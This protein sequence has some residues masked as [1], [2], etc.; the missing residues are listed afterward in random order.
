LPSWSDLLALVERLEGTDFEDFVV[1]MPGLTV[2][3][4]R[5]G[6]VGAGEADATVTEPTISE[7]AV[8]E[9]TVT[10]PA[11]TEPT[12]A[13]PAATERTVAEPAAGPP[14][15]PDDAGHQDGVEITAPIVGLFFRRPAPDQ[16]PFVDVGDDVTVGATMAIVEVMK[17]MVPVEASIAGRVV[18]V[19]V[20]DGDLVEADQP[21]F[22]VDT[23]GVT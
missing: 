11:V 13:E 16:P 22:V 12:V 4:S 1:E 23:S 20:E 18:A 19:L 6:L 21:L 15:A 2:R 14:S 5:R 7:V 17:M 3:V 10:E 8:T 9:P